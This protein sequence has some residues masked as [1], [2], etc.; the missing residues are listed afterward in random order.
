M[1]NIL[2]VL[3]GDATAYNFQET[4]LP[5]DVLV[6]RE[7]LSQGPLNS[8]IASG[9]FWTARANWIG[10]TFG[11]SA[12]EYLTQV[13]VPL[14]KLKAAYDEINLWFEFDLH[15]QANLLG[16]L[17]LLAN[18]TNLSPPAV[19]LICPG[20]FPG[21]N[22]FKGMGELT[23]KELQYLF[24]TIRVELGEPDFFVAARA[25]VQYVEGNAKTIEKWIGETTFWGALALV[26]PAMEAHMRRLQ[27]DSRGLNYI[28]QCLL[29][30]YQ[31]GAR[32]KRELYQQ[33]WDTQPIYGMG[34]LE[35]DLYLKHLEAKSL[36]KF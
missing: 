24:D 7:I 4:G 29:T 19:F 12:S 6:W 3:N 15:C 13:V 9:E 11:E 35:I 5:G 22:N 14:E 17:A 2:H 27:T 10:Q 33:F 16:V 20:D 25:W 30:L 26:K 21:K 8:A 31:T 18:N 1:S 32:T 28:E 23:A 34:D 36:I